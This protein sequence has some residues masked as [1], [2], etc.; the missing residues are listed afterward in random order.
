M[1]KA[2]GRIQRVVRSDRFRVVPHLFGGCLQTFYGAVWN[3]GGG[4]DDPEGVSRRKNCCDD[5]LVRIGRGLEGWV[6][7]GCYQVEDFLN[8]KWNI[9]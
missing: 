9:M 5:G 2:R 8:R 1:N 4:G 6:A 3:C 7:P